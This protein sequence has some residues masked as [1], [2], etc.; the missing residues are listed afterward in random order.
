MSPRSTWM[1]AG[2]VGAFHLGAGGRRMSRIPGLEHCYRLSSSSSSTGTSFRQAL[3]SGP[4]VA[5]V[6]VALGQAPLALPARA[7]PPLG[8]PD[9]DAA[10]DAGH[11]HLALEAGELPE[12]GRDGDA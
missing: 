12:M 11:H 1:E 8:V 4:D 7:S 3:G 10:E 6:G 9:L 2:G 5:Q